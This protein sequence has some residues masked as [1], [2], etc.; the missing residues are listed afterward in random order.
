MNSVARKPL[1]A[2]WSVLV[3]AAA[4]NYGMARAADAPVAGP[5]IAQYLRLHD[6][7]TRI[8]AQA[9]ATVGNTSGEPCVRQAEQPRS[10]PKGGRG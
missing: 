8:S 1:V 9:A 7:A 6:E 10:E 5:D 4:L 2:V 3:I